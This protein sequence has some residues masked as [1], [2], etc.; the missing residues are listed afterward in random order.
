MTKIAGRGSP[1]APL[2]GHSGADDAFQK[3]VKNQPNIDIDV[4]AVTLVLHVPV[5]FV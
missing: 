5:D 1:E 4:V 2:G 3:C